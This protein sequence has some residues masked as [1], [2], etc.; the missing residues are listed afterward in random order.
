M[1]GVIM[2]TGGGTKLF[3][4]IGVKYSAGLT[5]TCTNG[6]KT[7][8]AKTTSGQWVFAIPETGTWIVTATD[9]ADPT[10]TKSETV[11]I[12]TE[13]QNVNVDLAELVLFDFGNQCEDITGGWGVLN[14][15]SSNASIKDDS[16]YVGNTGTGGHGHMA[17]TINK[18]KVD[19]YKTLKASV[20]VTDAGHIF[21]VSNTRE[22]LGNTFV[23]SVT[24]ST[25]GFDTLE[26]PVENV[27]GAY[28]ILFQGESAKM[29]VFRVW[30]E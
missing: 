21:G 19:G 20:N 18:V 1:K 2:I 13:G 9:P 29:T 22:R 7:F 6:T 26:L 25:L 12:T 5:L 23:A 10:K 17:A 24:T 27:V 15:S 3:A 4:A 16:I 30:L 14:G 8:K 11:E 28:Y